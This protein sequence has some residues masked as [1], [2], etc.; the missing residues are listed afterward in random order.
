MYFNLPTAEQVKVCL[1]VAA[2][3]EVGKSYIDFH[4]QFQASP[5][6]SW[7]LSQLPA[8][9]VPAFGSVDEV[10][11]DQSARVQSKSLAQRPAHRRDTTTT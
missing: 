7:A 4:R 8:A 2:Q 3:Y 6:Q 10:T 5:L 11:H 9:L 1:N